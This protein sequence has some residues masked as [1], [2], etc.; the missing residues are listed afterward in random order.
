MSNFWKAPL[1]TFVLCVFPTFSQQAPG[2]TNGQVTP[3][4]EITGKERA[5]W[6]VTSTVGPESLLLAG[7]WSAGWGVLTSS[8]KEYPRNWEGFG[9][10]YGMRLTGVVTSNAME[11]AL[12]A[13]WH[14][15]PRYF[16]MGPASPF[17]SRVKH[18]IVATFTAPGPDGRFRPAYARY[19]AYV[20]SNFLANTWR[21]ESEADWQSALVRVATGFGGRMA[22]QAFNELWPDV[23]RI[24]FKKP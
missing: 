9:Q 14:E 15:D 7:P 3:Y 18:I 12:S 24:V 21:V 13:T 2:I 5:K 10:R 16:R 17:K 19:A 20:G 11:A 1:G 4:T 23:R 8:P 22:G 6:F